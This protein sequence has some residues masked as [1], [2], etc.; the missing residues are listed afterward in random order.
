MKHT[1]GIL[2][3]GSLWLPFL[4]GTLLSFSG[5]CPARADGGSTTPAEPLGVSIATAFIETERGWLDNGVIRV[6]TD[7]RY[8]GA[9]VY[10]SAAGSAENLINIHDK[11]RQIQQSYYSGKSLDR[12]ADGQSPHWSPWAWNPVQAGNFEGDSS[13]VLHFETRENSTVLFS[14]CQPRL[15]DMNEELARCHFSQS[16]QFEAAMNNVVCV[17]N[18]IV[19]FRNPNDPWGPPAARSQE[20]P[21]VYAIRNLSRMVIYDGDKPWTNDALTSV[22][23]GPADTWIWTRQKPTEPWAACVDPVTQ[24]GL[25]VYSPAGT[26]NTW[27]MGWVGPEE[28]TEYSGATMHFAPLASWSL[29]PD[30]HRTYR[31]WII[32][33]NLTE[34]RNR[35]Y[36]LHTRYPNG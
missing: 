3:K 34:I 10:A 19:C 25:G 21:A 33:G 16:M 36:Q 4:I 2:L 18:T 1:I 28:G 13:I 12:R 24:R 32:L 29:A 26:G 30:S 7:K 6:G 27:N 15:W 23:Y 20:L 8:G 17:T 31:Y 35:A 5:P 9:I 11:G 22:Q 14:Q